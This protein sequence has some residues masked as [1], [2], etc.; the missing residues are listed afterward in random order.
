[1]PMAACAQFLL[2][3]AIQQFFKAWCEVK[4]NND[5][6]VNACATTQEE[7]DTFVTL[8]FTHQLR[9]IQVC[10][11]V[12]RQNLLPFS[13]AQS[14]LVKIYSGPLAPQ[15]HSFIEPTLGHTQ[16]LLK[17]LNYSEPVGLRKF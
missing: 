10:K 7:V 8:L 17:T 14:S 6:A 9:W 16:L 11:Q 3:K 4:S 2:Q 1:M 13:P 5:F 15:L 12:S